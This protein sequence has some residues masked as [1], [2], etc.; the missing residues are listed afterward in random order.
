MAAQQHRHGNVLEGIEEDA[1]YAPDVWTDDVG[2]YA[3][4]SKSLCWKHHVHRG[5]GC[6]R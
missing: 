3:I 1:W 4:I 5:D 2:Y 6:G